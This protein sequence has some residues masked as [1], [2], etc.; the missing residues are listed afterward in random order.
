MT[1]IE[2]ERFS[3]FAVS[4][5]PTA[6]TFRKTPFFW[7]I[8]ILHCQ[9]VDLRAASGERRER[10]MGGQRGEIYWSASPREV[11]RGRKSPVPRHENAYEQRFTS[12]FAP[13][14]RWKCEILAIFRSSV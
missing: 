8:I 2:Y 10:T 1:L 7:R 11:K 13:L 5:F 3:V 4:I 9:L 6:P 14:L 12:Q